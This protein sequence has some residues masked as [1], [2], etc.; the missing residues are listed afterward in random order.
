MN[1][2]IR[3]VHGAGARRAFRAGCQHDRP[4]ADGLVKFNQDHLRICLRGIWQ[5]DKGFGIAVDQK[6]PPSMSTVL[7]VIF[8]DSLAI[9]DPSSLCG[10]L[11]AS[12][13]MSR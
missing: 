12:T 2:I 5:A 6:T 13:A 11:N 1:P 4:G 9:D 3:Q 7:E 10:V 8:G